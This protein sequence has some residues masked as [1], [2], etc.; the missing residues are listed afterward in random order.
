MNPLRPA[1]LAAAGS[2]RMKRAIT[3]FPVTAEV[4]HRFVA[5][6]SRADLAPVVAELLASGR[7]VSVDFLG[8]YT[9]ERSMAD[10]AV[11][12]YLA[13]IDELARWRRAAGLDRDSTARP[14][15]AMRR[16]VDG[17]AAGPRPDGS[18]GGNR[19]RQPGAT[20]AGAAVDASR[21]EPGT[22]P[23]PAQ[24]IAPVEVSVK[25]SALGQSLGLTG[26]EIAAANLRTLCER[27]QQAGVWITV[28]A[29]D[30]TTTETTEST[31]RALRPDYPWLAVATQ[32]YLRRAEER[33]RIAAAEGARI[34]LC[35]GAYREPESVAYQRGADVDESYLRCLELLM[36]G[37]GYPM[38]ATHDPVMI[39]AAHDLSGRN[40]RAPGDFEFQMLYGIR[41]IE[42]R[43]LVEA[44]HAVRVY[45]PY[46]TQWY[47]YLMRR[48]AERPAN[49]GFF[50][51]ALAERR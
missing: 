36:A 31:V 45:V 12:E 18:G 38:V 48:L 47:G 41:S 32:T 29:E 22:P 51:R 14:R 11:A 24:S 46:G 42:Q 26:P 27:A 17:E 30:H 13:L 49:L 7:M 37:S 44:G 50:L 23:R 10:D 21:A 25:L 15:G 39:T 28:D 1:I 16:H 35:K 6:E 40:G 20:T 34:R 4:V 33:C 8:E 2:S 5:G 43:R 3:G 9:T 19:A